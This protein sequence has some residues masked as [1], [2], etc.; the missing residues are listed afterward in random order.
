M[1]VQTIHAG[2]LDLQYCFYI[3]LMWGLSGEHREQL[4][5]RYWC[6]DIGKDDWVPTLSEIRAKCSAIL[7]E[8]TPEKFCEKYRRFVL[9]SSQGRVGTKGMK[10]LERY[11][12]L[13]ETSP[14]SSRPPYH[15]YYIHACLIGL[16][17]SW[18]ESFSK[19]PQ[20]RTFGQILSDPSRSV[21]TATLQWFSTTTFLV[22]L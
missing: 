11:R 19:N 4:M 6:A 16:F 8:K 7:L 15:Q 9:R 2:K 10:G 22:V 14:G 1:G 5:E 20:R 21:F 13:G 12:R 3:N 18:P 17:L